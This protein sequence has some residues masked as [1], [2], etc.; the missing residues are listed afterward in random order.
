MYQHTVL[1]IGIE[2]WPRYVILLWGDTENNHEIISW[3]AITKTEQDKRHFRWG[4]HR[5]PISARMTRFPET[6][7]I[8]SCCPSAI[9]NYVPFP[10]QD[11]LSSIIILE[12][13]YERE[14]DR[15]GLKEIRAFHGGP[16][17]ILM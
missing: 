10:S 3:S 12:P 4:D 14:E 8:Y 6:N 9:I 17:E 15:V 2:W 16:T 1:N 11:C 13:K 5:K 7:P